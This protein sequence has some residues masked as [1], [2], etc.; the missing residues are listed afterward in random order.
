M[1]YLVQKYSCFVTVF[2]YLQNS[3]E[4]NFSI[5]DINQVCGLFVDLEVQK[6][7]ALE[8]QISDVVWHISSRCQNVDEQLGEVTIQKQS[9][10]IFFILLE[11]LDRGEASNENNNSKLCVCRSCKMFPCSCQ[12]IYEVANVIDIQK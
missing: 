12:T 8:K 7:S 4:L 2:E 6:S 1:T 11:S 5:S 9:I 3:I 10:E